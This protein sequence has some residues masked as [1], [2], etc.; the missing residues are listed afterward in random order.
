MTDFLDLGDVTLAYDIHGAEHA[1]PPLLLVH[2]F[3]GARLDWA[4]VVQPL[5]DRRPVV[6]YD[7]RGHGE[8]TNFGSEA[9]YTFDALVNDLERFVDARVGDQAFDLLGH[10]MGG[11][12][13]LRYTLAHPERVRSFIPMDT[14]SAPIDIPEAF[15]AP[16]LEIGRTQG[17][18]AVAAMVGQ[19]MQGVDLPAERRTA[20]TRRLQWK[21]EH[22]DIEAFAA[23]ARGLR[24]FPSLTGRLGEISCPTTVVVGENDATLRGPADV[25]AAAVADAKL[26]V[27]PDAAHSPQEENTAAWL[28][29]IE[30]HLSRM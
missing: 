18:G 15:T 25:Y 14:F 2:G 30:E 16:I 6:A 23:L 9:A 28:L 26:A 10:S 4:D 24:T 20:M 7:Q 29:A 3:T 22:L 12:I 27:V 8:S 11:V 1:G 19:F 5:A 17:T 21:F 13:A